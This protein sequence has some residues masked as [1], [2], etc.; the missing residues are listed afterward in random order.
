MNA[1]NTAV[2]SNK[3]NV[4]FAFKM[5]NMLTIRLTCIQFKN[6]SIIAM[7]EGS[8]V[9]VKNCTASACK[10]SVFQINRGISLYVSN[11]KFSNMICEKNAKFSSIVFKNSE[12][13]VRFWGKFW[14]K[15][16]AR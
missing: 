16:N 4:Y 1:R 2:I 14:G 13:F 6:I 12:F 3:G 5:V 11:S 7:H 8:S 15:R 10:T 9:I